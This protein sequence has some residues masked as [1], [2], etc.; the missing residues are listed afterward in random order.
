MPLNPFV[1]KLHAFMKTSPFFK[2]LMLVALGT[3]LAP[4]TGLAQDKPIVIQNQRELFVDDYLVEKLDR[5]E[6]RLGVPASGGKAL[7]FNEPWEGLFSLAGSVVNDGIM[8]RMYYR[9]LPGT[10]ET[11]P[12]NNCYAESVDGI[13]WKKPALRQVEFKGSLE[14]NII[15]DGVHV[16]M[17]DDKPGIPYRQKYK[18]LKGGTKT[19][20][21][22]MVS[23]DG[24]HWKRLDETPD[25]VGVAKGHALDS[26]NVL[27]WVPSENQYAIYMRDWTGF[28]LGAPT[29]KE[30]NEFGNIHPFYHGVRTLMRSTS[31]DLIHW[32]DPVRM[33][34]GDT[35]VEHFYTNATQ[36][37][38]RAP[39]ILIAMPMRYK[40][41][42]NANVL[43]NAELKANGIHPVQWMGVSD[44][45]LL[46]SRGGNSFDRKFVESF[47]RPGLSQQ[48]WGA[49]SQIA[50]MGVIPTG[51]GEISFFVTR[52]YATKDVFVERMTLRT[53]G[54]ASLHAGYPEGSA[55]TKP[56]TLRG[57]R[58]ELN[59]SC[60]PVGYVKI[61]LLD[62]AGKELPGFGLADAEPIRG[63]KIDGKVKWKSG[64]IVRDA[65]DQKVRIKFI[66]KDADIYSFG[67]FD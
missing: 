45:V 54:F 9:G 39:Q 23:G 22:V 52:G 21:Y 51:P 65:G 63:D 42:W 49:R 60:S 56:L 48:N 34:F 43:S 32:T 12:S 31:T 61:V 27:A 44:T 11:T 24:F 7:E 35:P 1:L 5:M 28:T 47:V 53:D 8:Y 55:T 41:D 16:V 59:Y 66:A 57:N 62:E 14:N 4:L 40:P 20:L 19:G 15:K 13:H 33:T 10:S 67:I 17:Y 46:T 58:M 36:A 64:K 29:P 25:A 37:Y 30:P 2:R 18:T 26:P 38:F 6:S 3:W 50:A